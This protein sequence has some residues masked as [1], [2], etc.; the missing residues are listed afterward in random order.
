MGE[1]LEIASFIVTP[2]VAVLAVGAGAAAYFYGRF[3][4]LT[5]AAVAPL[6]S[7]T[8]KSLSWRLRPDA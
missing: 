6:L 1:N 3:G 4:R 2:L 5:A 7:I 8:I